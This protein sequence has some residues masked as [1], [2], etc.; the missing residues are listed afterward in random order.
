MESHSQDRHRALMGAAYFIS[1][2]LILFAYLDFVLNIWPLNAGEARWRF[3]SVGVFSSYTGWLLLGYLLLL[4]F[5]MAAGNRGLLKVVAVLCLIEGI[6]LLLATL[7]FPLDVLQLRNGVPPT[8]LWTFE[9]AAART[10]VKNLLSVVAF[11]WMAVA[12]FR[13]AKPEPGSRSRRTE[14]SPLI[15]GSDRG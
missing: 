9:A 6:L 8:D 5:A 15:V 11:F 3:G 4:W 14:P 10:V 7:A 2:L 12:G 1:I 13:G